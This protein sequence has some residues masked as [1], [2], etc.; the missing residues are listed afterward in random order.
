MTM[1]AEA[2]PTYW[3]FDYDG[4][5]LLVERDWERVYRSYLH[6]LGVI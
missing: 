3:Q 5:A 6:G 2:S 1:D 4:E